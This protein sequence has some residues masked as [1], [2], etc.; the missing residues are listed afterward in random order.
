MGRIVVTAFSSLDGVVEAPGGEEF[1]YEGWSFEFDRGDEG[2]QFKI[3][4]AL[5]ADAL[6]VG[7]LTYEGFAAAWPHERGDLADKYNSMPKYVVS[8]TLTDPTWT[9]TH[10]LG[11]PVPE[12][13]A[14]LKDRVDGEIQVPGSIRLV[15]DLFRHDLVDEL[16]IMMFPVILGTG[17]RLVDSTLDKSAWRLTQAR[18]VG[19]GVLITIHQRRR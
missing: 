2:E 3:D 18:P 10:V 11:G 16:R 5:A 12:E 13:V 15:H 19:D 8:T 6:L 17:R 4:E 9:N 14:A 1:A 7:R